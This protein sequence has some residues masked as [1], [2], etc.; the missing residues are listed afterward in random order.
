[1][2]FPRQEYW[3]GLPY[4]FPGDVPDP[5]IKPQSPVSLALAGGFFTTEPHG[6]LPGL[7]ESLVILSWRF[8]TRGDSALWGHAA[9]SRDTLGCHMWAEGCY[10]HPEGRAQGCHSAFYKA[11]DGPV[12]KLSPAEVEE[13][14]SERGATEREREP[15]PGSC[16]PPPPQEKLVAP[17]SLIMVTRRGESVPPVIFPFSHIPP[18]S[19]TEQKQ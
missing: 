6:K 9:M 8:S 3:S 10:W 1:M 11:Q 16:L 7:L 17:P 14:C 15:G 2:G 4:P 5:G 12:P 19:S 13:A 18:K